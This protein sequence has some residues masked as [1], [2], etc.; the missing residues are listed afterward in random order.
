MKQLILAILL[1]IVNC[2]R[3]T[4]DIYVES[5]CPY[6]MMFIK[7]S[8]LTAITTPDIEQMV[9]IRLIPYGNTKRKIVD[10]KWVFTCQHGEVECYGDLIE[11]CAQ[12]S[13]VKALGTVAAEI[14]KAGVV[15]CIEDFI[16][17]PYTNNSFVEAAQ[18]C[19]QYYPY[20]ANEVINCASSA[21][22]ELLHLIAA[23]ETDNLVPK[24]KGVPWAVANKQYTEET[25]DEII[26][27]L[28]RWACNNYDGEKIAACYTQQE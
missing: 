21:Y 28:L 2:G 1:I 18:H 15:H 5:L 25:G 22:G 8:L 3:L 17:K 13:I 26:N 16:Q 27:N 7:D 9:H 4:A 6:C 23:D 10:G 12:D 14:P 19:Q 20:E 11:L 24:H